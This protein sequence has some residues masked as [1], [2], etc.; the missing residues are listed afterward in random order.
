MDTSLRG[1][2]VVENISSG[3]TR[4]KFGDG[5]SVCDVTAAYTILAND[6]VIRVT[7]TD[8]ARTLTL[9]ALSSA[10]VG[11]TFTI[12]DASA[13]AATNNITVVDAA[14]QTVATIATN[15]GRVD[16][17]GKS[18]GWVVAENDDVPADASITMAKLASLAGLSLIGRSANTA[19]APAAITAASDDHILRRSGTSIGF[20]TIA[21]GGIASNAVT[22][23]K[24]LDANVTLAKIAD[25]T[26]LSVIGRGANSAGVNADIVGTDGQVLRVAGTALG[27]GAIAAAGITDAVLTGAKAAVVADDAVVGGIPVVLNIAIADG[28]TADK[29]IVLTHKT[30]ILEVV[31]QKRGAAGG[32]SDTIQLKNTADAITNALD[33]NVADKTIVRPGTIDDAFSTIAAAGT[34]RIT[35]TKASA[36]N[37]ACQVTIFGV[38]R[39]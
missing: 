34:L 3:G 29:D 4:H 24:I 26:G 13:G 21:A 38:R 1:G 16:I 5:S 7:N 33:I 10:V 17:T 15:G 8:S 25:G 18:G 22:T 28:V 32:A 9:P 12:E 6:R 37:T 35:M 20:G 2:F 36:E 23:A 14:A 30:E 27:F 19:G 39:T 31:V 11:W